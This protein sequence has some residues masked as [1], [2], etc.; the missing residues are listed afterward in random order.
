M[1]IA[2]AF[3]ILCVWI[4]RWRTDTHNF[5]LGYEAI[6]IA[7]SIVGG[8][9]FSSPYL[10]N[11]GPS[12][13]LTPVYPYLLAVIFK[14]WGAQTRAAILAA[15]ALNEVF[16]VLTCIPVFFVAKRVGGPRLALTASLLW[17]V[18]PL[19]A[20]VAF[21]AVWYSSLSALLLACALWATLAIR[22]S[23][24]T[25]D[26]IGYGL[27]WGAN[28]LTNATAASL[29]P[30]VLAWLIWKR[31]AGSGRVQR[32]L[33]AAFVMVLVCLPWMI[34]NYDVFHA[35][36][37][38]RSNFGATL[39]QANVPGA[40]DP[41][42]SFAERASMAEMGEVAYSQDRQQ[43]ALAFMISDAQAHPQHMAEKV[44]QRMNRL[45]MG[46]SH[47]LDQ[48]DSEWPRIV[49][50]LG[51]CAMGLL[52]LIFLYRRSLDQFWLFVVFPVSFPLV[53]YL[54]VS[55]NIYRHP[56]DPALVVLA[57]YGLDGLD[58]QKRAGLGRFATRGPA[59]SV[60]MPISAKECEQ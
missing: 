11:T 5:V 23:E 33:L 55:S 18:Y 52:G 17:A 41:T 40:G 25:R 38:L 14:V 21:D 28:L 1:I 32:P 36:V 30:F 53:Y 29:L 34:R 60:V 46:I 43:R 50:N 7:D 3:R 45:W 48:F 20:L 56:I 31:S 13:W 4:T 2:I 47:P 44:F 10:T 8:K 9:G 58:R 39:W 16:S 49:T 6:G 22:D 59:T 19:S 54:T 15:L 24:R 57:A 35:F 12:A 37:P 42:D 27:L 26:W 51:L